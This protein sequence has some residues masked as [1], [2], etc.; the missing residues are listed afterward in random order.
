M[1]R[2]AS[3]DLAADVPF[4]ERQDE[5]GAMAAALEKFKN[6]AVEN[7]RLREERVQSDEQ[8]RAIKKQ[9]LLDMAESVER[10]TGSSVEAAA[11]AT[12]EVEQT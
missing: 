12:N 5:V 1:K 7:A 3:G 2:L 8:A 4:A 9:A 6:S 10:E 11:S